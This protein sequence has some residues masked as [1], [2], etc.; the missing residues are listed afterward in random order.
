VSRLHKFYECTCNEVGCR[1]CDGGLGLCTVCNGFEGTLTKECCGRRI[2]EKE[3]HRI[4]DVGDLDYKDGVWIWKKESKWDYYNRLS[5]E[6][7][8]EQHE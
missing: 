8:A 2:T 6:G 7:R 4:Y 1:F 5:E 3:E